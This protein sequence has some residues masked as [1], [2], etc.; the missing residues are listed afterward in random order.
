MKVSDNK[1]HTHEISTA[2]RIIQEINLRKKT[3]IE[4]KQYIVMT[5]SYL[6]WSGGYAE[7]KGLQISKLGS[8]KAKFLASSHDIHFSL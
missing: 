4:R 7:M 2:T 8:P 6:K 3:V 5:G 1:K